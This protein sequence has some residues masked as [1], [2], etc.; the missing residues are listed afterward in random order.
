MA[1]DCDIIVLGAGTNAFAGTRL[2]AAAGK[3]V[4]LVEQSQPGGTCV[5]W[6]YIPSKR[7]C[8]QTGHPRPA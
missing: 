8:R 4:L 7:S 1:N 5:N 2:A 3:K 6:G